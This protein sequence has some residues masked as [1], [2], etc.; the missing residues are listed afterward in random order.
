MKQSLPDGAKAQCARQFCSKWCSKTPERRQVL[1]FI[2]SF[3]SFSFF[4]Q[5]SIFL[6]LF[7]FRFFSQTCHVFCYES[8]QVWFLVFV[9]FVFKSRK[10]SWLSH[11][12]CG[13]TFAWKDVRFFLL[14]FSSFFYQSVSVWNL[15]RQQRFQTVFNGSNNSRGRPVGL[16]I[17]LPKKAQLRSKTASSSTTQKVEVFLKGQKKAQLRSQNSL[18]EHNAKKYKCF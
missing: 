18:F 17:L 1:F 7:L 6:L 11:S 8:C 14:Y 3:L 5:L 15:R 2:F 9:F 12:V 4:R 10:A 16:F 13:Q